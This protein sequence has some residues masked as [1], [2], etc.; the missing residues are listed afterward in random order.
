[1]NL[2]LDFT[3]LNLELSNFQDGRHMLRTW[4]T[5]QKQQTQNSELTCLR[6][7]AHTQRRTPTG[8]ITASLANCEE[9]KFH[10][11]YDSAPV[12]REPFGWTTG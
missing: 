9:Q 2:R 3:I 4:T 1:M 5:H 11:Q 6:I 12:N 10:K 7:W 8:G